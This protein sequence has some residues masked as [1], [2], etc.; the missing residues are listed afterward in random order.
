MSEDKDALDTAQVHAAVERIAY[1][2][3]RGGPSTVHA[4]RMSRI[5]GYPVVAMRRKDLAADLVEKVL[6]DWEGRRSE[7]RV[8]L[9]WAQRGAPA[10]GGCAHAPLHGQE[11]RDY[12]WAVDVAATFYLLGVALPVALPAIRRL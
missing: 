11:G 3:A 2:R 8:R 12:L 6:A 9:W 7:K 1:E 4:A 5:V 10:D